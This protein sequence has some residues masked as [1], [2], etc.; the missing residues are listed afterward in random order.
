MGVQAQWEFF[1][2]MQRS[3]EIAQARAKFRAAQQD[4]QKA[5]SNLRLDL[6]QSHY[7]AAEA[8]QRLEVAGAALDSARESLRITRVRYQEGAASVTELLVAEVGLTETTTRDVAAY[9][10][11]L[12][13]LSNLKRAQGRLV[14]QWAAPDATSAPTGGGQP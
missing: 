6:R 9:Y 2:G 14:S 1:T 4:E 13:A 5:L 3:G 7:Q 12:I 10:D 11:Y 8:R